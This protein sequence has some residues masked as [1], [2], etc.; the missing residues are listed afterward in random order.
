MLKPNPYVT[1]F[2]NGRQLKTNHLKSTTDPVFNQDLEF[3]NVLETDEIIVNVFD[4]EVVGK[5]DFLGECRLTS[6]DWV[7]GAEAWF[8][9]RA[10]ERRFDQVQGDIQLRFATIYA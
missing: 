8:Q 2:L 3:R 9:L 4:K 1:L 6:K 10:R 5:D 7:N